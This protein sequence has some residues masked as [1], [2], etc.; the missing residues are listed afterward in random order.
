L[1]KF[2]IDTQKFDLQTCEN[3]AF[4]CKFLNILLLRHAQF[5]KDT[6][7]CEFNTYEYDFSKQ[8]CDFDTHEYYN[9]MHEYDLY[10]QS[11]I[12]TRCVI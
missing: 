4:A 5:S 11:D 6:H 12:S 9:D 10:T 1:K 7:K 8:V 2:R 3:D